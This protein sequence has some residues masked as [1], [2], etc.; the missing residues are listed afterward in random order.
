[1]RKRKIKNKRK[2]TRK[3][4]RRKMPRTLKRRA[5]KKRRK[6]LKRLLKRLLDIQKKAK[7]LMNGS[8]PMIQSQLQLIQF[9]KPQF[10]KLILTTVPIK[11]ELAENHIQMPANVH[12]LRMMKITASN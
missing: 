11:P 9:Q 4:M 8:M 2:R 5:R 1:M 6:L 10:K 12:T 7:K 3:R